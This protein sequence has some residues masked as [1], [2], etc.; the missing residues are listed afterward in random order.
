MKI[1]LPPPLTHAPEARSAWQDF[2]LLLGS[3]VH[4]SWQK[5]RHWPIG[6]WIGMVVA[7]AGLLAVLVYL[8]FAAYG[9]LQAMPP[10]NARGFL[11]LLL[12]MGLAGQVFFGITAAFAALYM[13]ED[14][15]LL[16]VAPVSVRAV[17]AVKSLVVAGSNFLTVVLFALLP[18][19]FY[20]LLFQA[21]AL[22]YVLVILVSLGL[23]IIGTA[24]SQ[25]LN[26]LVMRVVPPHRS[27]EAIGV[28]GAL[29]GI[30]IAVVFQ[31]PG[32]L[33]HNKS[34]N[35]GAW[36][37]GQQQM[38]KI[39]D[40]FPW[41]WGSR[42]LA[43]GVSGSLPAGLGWSLLLLAVGAALYCL[44]FLLV[45]RGF[46]RGWISLSQGGGGRR[47]KGSPHAKPARSLP[48]ESVPVLT[49]GRVVAGK[50]SPWL[51][52]WAVAK[53]DLLY[54]RRDTREW[55]G[56][57]M[58]L[59][60]MVF[61][62][63]QTLLLPS[64]ATRGSAIMVLVIYS[65][66]F[67]GN[68]ALQSFG[69]EGEADWVINS[70][71]L[72]GWP[73]V[74]GK[75]VA[76][77]L[78]TLLLMEAL[79]VGT[80]AALGSSVALTVSLAVGAVLLTLGA[81]AIGLYYSVNNSRYNPDSPQMRVSPVASILMYLVNLLFMLFLALGLLYI[82]PPAELTAVLPQMPAVSFSWGFP[83]TILY[84]LY[85]L[86]RPLLWAPPW[87]ILLGVAVAGG[88]WALVFYSFMAATV[89]QSRKG[90]RVQSITGAKKK[91]GRRKLFK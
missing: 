31:L 32:L 88:L 16:F 66:M 8:G 77:A 2:K 64:E 71:P 76:A 73:V 74:W 5:I 6:A 48:Q 10:Q 80:M 91:T 17:F 40:Y 25:L 15:E 43:G 26:M 55:F 56:Y 23:W 12:M 46:R 58:P 86:S 24:L 89:R 3:Q 69:R 39:M 28:V 35:M 75:L 18:G 27:R 54:V 7:G 62:V 42:A 29:G 81:S 45:Q 78:P 67:S 37:A 47:K 41:G 36:L 59:I 33:M 84:G 90:L 85:A 68:M 44:S 60:I 1:A 61:F 13:S 49:A 63:G 51:G 53:K 79:L 11:S 83:E 57:M 65:M 19:I 38:L 82:L 4:V 9:A 70:V 52:M 87:R 22:F 21:G 34:L 72:A 50:A 20:G 14:L 30:V